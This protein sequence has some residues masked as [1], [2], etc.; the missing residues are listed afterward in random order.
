MT[1]A[2]R[3]GC[4]L[5]YE[6]SAIDK[7]ILGAGFGWGV[8]TALALDVT[9]KG[10][11]TPAQKAF[12]NNEVDEI[13]GALNGQGEPSVFNWTVVITPEPDT[14]TLVPAG[15]LLFWMLRRRFSR[16]VLSRA[17]AAPDLT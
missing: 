11:W 6:M 8:T 10:A 5:P 14:Y 12:V 4:A 2:P 9:F 13:V 17:S 16:S 1:Q 15:L 3:G 7:G